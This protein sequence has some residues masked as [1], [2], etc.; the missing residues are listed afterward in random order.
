[1]Y[2]IRTSKHLC[3][4]SI[5]ESPHV[6]SQLAMVAQE[7]HVG[8]VHQDPATSLLVEVLFTTQRCEAPVLGD[9]DLLATRELVL[10]TA[11]RLQSRSPVCTW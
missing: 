3:R 4:K 1:M 8:T 5:R 6:I 11:E 9:D 7:L 10:R 2:V